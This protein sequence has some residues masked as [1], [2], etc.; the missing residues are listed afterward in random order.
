[1]ILSWVQKSHLNVSD[2]RRFGR[3]IDWSRGWLVVA[4]RVCVCV[5]SLNWWKKANKIPKYV[6][7][8]FSVAI[9][10]LTTSKIHES[11]SR[12]AWVPIARQNG[13]I[14]THLMRAQKQ[15]HKRTTYTK[16]KQTCKYASVCVSV[17]IYEFMFFSVCE[18]QISNANRGITT[19]N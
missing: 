8:T 3:N 6:I 16:H 14:S 10:V 12:R 2:V 18:W 1:M 19:F 17:Y 11:N 15:Q 4:S 7:A 13:C 5:W 9:V